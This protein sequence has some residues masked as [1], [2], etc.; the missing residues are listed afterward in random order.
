MFLSHHQTPVYQ[1][2]YNN[3]PGQETDSTCESNDCTIRVVECE[4]LAG[5]NGGAVVSPSLPPSAA[6]LAFAPS[7]TSVNKYVSN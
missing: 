7:T 1:S 2:Y 6:V 4:S 3:D 5:A